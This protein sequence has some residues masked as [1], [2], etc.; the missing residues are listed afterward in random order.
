MA[1]RRY[2]SCR[3]LGCLM[4]TPSLCQMRGT[5]NLLNASRRC[6]KLWNTNWRLPERT[7]E[8]LNPKYIEEL[9]LVS[10]DPDIW[11]PSQHTVQQDVEQLYEGMAH[12]VTA[13]F[14]IMDGSIVYFWSSVSNNHLG[15]WND[16][17]ESI[18]PSM[19]QAH[20]S[21][22]N[23][24]HIS[25]FSIKTMLMVLSFFNK[26]YKQRRAVGAAS[27]LTVGL[28]TAA[29]PADAELLDTNK[30]ELQDILNK[31]FDAETEAELH[32]CVIADAGQAEQDEQVIGGIRQ[33]AIADMAA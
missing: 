7:I 31:D 32:T 3:S 5:T 13:Y 23:W 33:K 28:A 9:R 22:M 1:L 18:F 4:W 19:L 8:K 17:Q 25:I 12:L 26:Q 16:I 30:Q 6:D 14:K 24:I 27:G 2:G 21:S 29:A 20:S 15:P 10:Q 11:V